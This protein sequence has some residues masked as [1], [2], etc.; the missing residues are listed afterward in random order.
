MFSKK[1]VKVKNIFIGGEHEIVIQSMTNTDTL[2]ISSTL[3]QINN[4]HELGAQLIR[5]SVR[6]LDDID[7]F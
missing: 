2:D 3:N 1:T 7:P 6:S 5:V 4:L